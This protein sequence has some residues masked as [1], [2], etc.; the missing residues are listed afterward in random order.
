MCHIWGRS[1]KYLASPL[2]GGL[3]SCSTYEYRCC[4]NFSRLELGRGG[5]CGRVLEFPIRILRSVFR[6]LVLIGAQVPRKQL[7]RRITWQSSRSR[8]S[9]RAIEGT[10]DSWDRGVTCIVLKE[11]YVNEQIVIFQKCMLNTYSN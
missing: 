1:V 8:I 7:P 9:R 10:W 2:D 5:E 4:Q 3:V 11:Y 6:F